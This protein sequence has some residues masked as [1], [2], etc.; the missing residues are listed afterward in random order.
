MP[1]PDIICF[2]SDNFNHTP[3]SILRYQGA[4]YSFNYK[5]GKGNMHFKKIKPEDSESKNQPHD[6]IDFDLNN[7]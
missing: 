7:I 1:A 6:I 5:D 2:P 4:M 3:S